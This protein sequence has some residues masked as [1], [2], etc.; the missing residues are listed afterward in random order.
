M[1]PSS[2]LMVYALCLSE[3]QDR[4]SAP[5]VCLFS[6]APWLVIALKRYGNSRV[7][8]I[9]DKQNQ[10]KLKTRTPSHLAAVD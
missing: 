4:T 5:S 2:I 9:G 1:I 3:D 6:A 7:A 10:T 8:M